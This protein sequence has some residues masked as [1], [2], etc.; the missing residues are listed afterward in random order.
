MTT[1]TYK[2]LFPAIKNLVVPN[3]EA[4]STIL[5]SALA[6]I[7]GGFYVLPIDSTTKNP[8]TVVGKGWLSYEL[9]F[10]RLLST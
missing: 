5:E 7:D 4:E 10:W 9:E 1:V 8:G 6:W 2:D 3:I